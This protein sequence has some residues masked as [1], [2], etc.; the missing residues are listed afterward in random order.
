MCECEGKTILRKENN[1]YKRVLVN[2]KNSEGA[3][4]LEHNS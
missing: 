2:S 1:K 3:N 4:L